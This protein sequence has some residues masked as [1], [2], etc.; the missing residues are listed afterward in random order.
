TTVRRLARIA[1]RV[2][3]A[4]CRAA[5]C[6]PT[7]GLRTAPRTAS[8]VGPGARRRAGPPRGGWPVE[9][10]ARGGGGPAW[11]RDGPRED[12]DDEHHR[13]DRDPE[14]QQDRGLGHGARLLVPHGPLDADPA[15]DT[16]SREPCRQDQPGARD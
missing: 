13:T 6:A 16:A 8:W 2:R 15:A 7:P 14:H 1:W 4:G 3:L 12:R 11:S 9:A 5:W 10:R